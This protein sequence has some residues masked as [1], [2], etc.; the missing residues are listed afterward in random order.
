M[1]KISTTFVAIF[2]TTLHSNAQ[3]SIKFGGQV[4]YHA[5]LNSQKNSAGSMLFL[6]KALSAGVTVNVGAAKSKISWPISIDYVTGNNNKGG[7]EV[8]AKAKDILFS[9]Y[10]FTKS[11]PGG[12]SVLAGPSIA[13]FPKVEKMPLIWLQL[14]AGAFFGN[15]Q[16]LQY[17]NQA[18][19]T[20]NEIKANAVSFNYRPQL[21]IVAVNGKKIQGRIN[22][23]YSSFGGIG[24][25]VGIS[26]V[27][28]RG[29]VCHKCPG[30][31]CW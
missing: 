20:V 21:S 18:G 31:G 25:G 29:M 9:T 16:G 28:C 4:N 7:A 22:I 6:N 23:G 19:A 3:T 10:T 1:Q 26:E 15:N 30:P 13:L 27:I 2:F 12:F 5:T 14:Q 11:N 17:K 8:Y 24:I